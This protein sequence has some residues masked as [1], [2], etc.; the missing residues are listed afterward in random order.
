MGLLL[1]SIYAYISGIIFVSVLISS[2]VDCRFEPW[3]IQTK[4][5]KIGICCFSAKHAALARKS[6]LVGPQSGQC[7]QVKSASTIRT[8]F[9]SEVS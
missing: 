9:P 1:S 7:F 3:L 8:M 4:D 5:Y 6:R 2:A